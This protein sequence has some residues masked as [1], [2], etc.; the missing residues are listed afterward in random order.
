MNNK[1]DGWDV[2]K[3]G[4]SRASKHFDAKKEAETWGRET[5]KNQNYLIHLIATMLNWRSFKLKILFRCKTKINGFVSQLGSEV[6]I[7]VF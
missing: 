3:G 6:I 4:S 1:D 2:K 5:S 7:N